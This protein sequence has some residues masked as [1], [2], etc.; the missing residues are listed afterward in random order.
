MF[1]V[2]SFGAPLLAAVFLF[3]VSAVDVPSRAETPGPKYAAIVEKDRPVAWWRFD[4]ATGVFANW[5]S[6]DRPETL[7]ADAV[8]EIRGERPG[9]RTPT[10]PL[11]D[12]KNQA[13]EISAGG[14]RLRVSDTG[15]SSELDF[16]SGDTI[17]LE[18]WIAPTS[19]S[20]GSYLYVVGKGRTNNPG[21]APDNQNYA[22]RLQGRGDS[23]ALS[24]LFRSRADG[25]YKGDWHRWT[26]NQSVPLGD[27][28]HHVAIVYTFG[29]GASLRGYI[30]GELAPGRWDMGG[31][32]DR[33]PVVD[34]DEVWIGSS[35]GG[36]TG[37]TFQGGLDEVAIYRQALSAERI[38][39]RYQYV[40][41]MPPVDVTKI[42]DNAVLVEIFESVPDR[43]SWD[44]RAPRYVESYMAPAFAFPATPNKYTPTGVIADR[45]NPYLVRATGYITFPVGER[46]ILVR[47]RNATRVYLDGE[48]IVET[49][50]HN[51]SSSGHGAVWELDASLAPKIRPLQRGDQQAVAVVQGDGQ[52]RLVQ[53]LTIVGGQSRRPELGETSVSIA[54]AE[55]DFAVLSQTL[56]IP[57]T[58][59][60]WREFSASQ[61]DWLVNLNQSRRREAS[62]EEAQYWARRHELARATVSQTPEVAVP[63]S[64]PDYPAH[65]EI[66]RF[67]NARLA[68]VGEKPTELID[69]LSF[70]RRVSLDA[71]GLVPTPEEIEAFL[72]DPPETRRSRVIERLLEH[73]SWADHW[74]GYWQDALAENPN[75]VNPTLNNTGPFR[76]WLHE[77][78]LDNKPMDRFVTELVM[79]EGSTHFGGPAGFGMATQNDAP[80]AAKALILGQAFLGVEMSCA[81]CHDAPFHDIAQK[82]LFSIAAMLKRDAQPVP[83][84]SSVPV[85]DGESGS[86]LITVTLKPGAQVAPEWPFSKLVE[87]NFDA[88]VLRR[89]GDPRERLA[90]LIT[91]PHNARFS[92]VIVN[93][94]WWRYLGLGLVDSVD[95]W[96]NA[97]PTHPELLDWLA[98]EFVLH[99]HDLKHIA[100]LIFNSHVYQRQAI[101]QEA[102]NTAE[103]YLFAGPLERRMAAEQLVDSLFRVCGKPFDSGPMNVDIDTARPYSVSLNLGEP[104]RSWMF[105]SLSNERD[106][107]SL[108]LP[109]AQPFIELL[110]AFGWRGSRPD[111]LTV[112]NEEPT[113]LQPGVLANEVL[114]RRVT[115]LTDDNVFT[116]QAMED[117]PVEKLI[118]NTYRRI[119]TRSPTQEELADWRE[120]LQPGYD[121][122]KI[123]PSPPPQ[124]PRKQPRGLVGWSNHLDPRANEIKLELEKAVRAGEPPTNR[125]QANWRERMEDMLWAL[126]NSPEF[127][128]V[129]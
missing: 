12:A 100:R 37:S 23:A 33:A 43:K 72:A 68:A 110:E 1:R 86:D 95:D 45:S 40:G 53:L 13:I 70:L 42:P 117:Q 102:T 62:E 38:R 78:F 106:R 36:Q 48:L 87:E 75:I 46:R 34:D 129:P 73:P 54:E 67:L 58:D 44:F 83:A 29:K 71:I 128:F 3:L 51:I 6:N 113:V 55:G 88:G 123:T 63:D 74:V 101:G 80:M 41:A 15:P 20:A 31:V 105:A 61:L 109:Y 103:P 77:S 35:M 26:S 8:G 2:R 24:F 39:A 64:P 69:D 119:L 21:F 50:F 120:F 76:W 127:V 19:A 66:D 97:S 82:D 92:R 60:G 57:L 93:R 7:K 4:D 99:G 89:P 114:G 124:T 56:D 107:P 98:R 111:A 126:I 14:G 18:A 16:D 112:R 116:S 104:T 25:D 79:M 90:A 118:E 85:A 84:T 9:P 47:G 27:G 59:D 65:N 10:F 121:D 96:E 108:A 32:T 17:T 122:R 49:P 28:W 91:S 11:F 52:R 5:A 125:L 30:D 81:R 94:L 22:L 115:R